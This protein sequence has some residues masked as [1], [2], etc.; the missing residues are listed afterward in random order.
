MTVKTAF[1]LHKTLPAALLLCAALALPLAGCAAKERTQP[2]DPALQSTQT[3]PAPAPVAP[4]SPPAAPDAQANAN[5]ASPAKAPSESATQTAAAAQPQSGKSAVA[6]MLEHA[7]RNA[8]AEQPESGFM[9]AVPDRVGDGEAFYISFGADTAQKVRIFW[10]GKKLELTGKN[11]ATG[12]FEALLPVALDEAAKKLPLE[13]TV[14]W[15]DGRSEVFATDLA[16]TRKQYPLQ[17]LRVAPKY[18]RHPPEM[19]EKVK[20]DRAELRAAVTKISPV[21]YWSLPLLRPVPGAVT[22]LFGAR[23]EFNNKK[24]NPH[25]GVDFDANAG[26]P[27]M[28]L[29]EGAVVLTGDHYYSGN[30]TVI[31]HGLGVMS[32]YLH[33]SAFNV[34]VGQ[35][36]QRGELIGFIGSTGRSTGPHL[37]LSLYVLGESVNA[38]PCIDM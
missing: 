33:Q 19:D 18:A 14:T 6:R 7:G 23:R 35:H 8:A 4:A 27:I 17:K 28:A 38:A 11:P 25:K 5:A 2:T 22:S 24:S 30:I 32:V 16:V 26:D 21:Q 12:R 34:S 1:S 13:L 10:R 15:A 29:E 9:L 37:H 20:Q 3:Q 36:V 31:D